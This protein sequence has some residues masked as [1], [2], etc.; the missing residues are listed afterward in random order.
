VLAALVA[1]EETQVTPVRQV[2]LVI[3]ATM[4]RVALLVMVALAVTGVALAIRVTYFLTVTVAQGVTP[5]VLRVIRVVVLF[6][7]AAGVAAARPEVAP[8]AMGAAGLFFASDL[9]VLA[10]AAVAVARV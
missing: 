6:A 8:E 9:F 5:V 10:V 7:P 4:V 2:M 3:P 1:P